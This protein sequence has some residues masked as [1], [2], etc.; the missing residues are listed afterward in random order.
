MNRPYLT[1]V[2]AVALLHLGLIWAMQRGFSAPRSPALAQV[3]VVSQIVKPAQPAE[4]MSQPAPQQI[5]KIHSGKAHEPV[6]LQSKPASDRQETVKESPIDAPGQPA[7][8]SAIVPSAAPSGAPV[9]AALVVASAQMSV[10]LPVSDADYLQNSP[11]PYPVASV[12]FNEQGR[13]TVRVLIGANGQAERAEVAK[14][15][16]YKRLDD[17]AVSSVLRWRYVPGK[18]GGVAEPM[19][20]E[21]PINWTLN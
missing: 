15:S 6:V 2:L 3:M 11:P 1:I 9:T 5:E 20:F 16:G 19:W 10:Q 21:V 17:A 4:A 7:T 8:S 18:R 12:R 14:S 13:T